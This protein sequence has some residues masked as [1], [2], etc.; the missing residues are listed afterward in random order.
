MCNLHG[1]VRAERRD[2]SAALR[3]QA[4]LPRG[5]H[6]E[7]AEAK[8]LLSYVQETSH[9]GRHKEPKE[10]EEKPKSLI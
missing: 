5:M 6:R 4:L 10:E 1:R 8:Q 2:D 3:R 9:N 7:L